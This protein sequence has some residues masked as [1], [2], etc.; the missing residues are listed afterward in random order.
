MAGD[1]AIEVKGLTKRFGARVALRDVSFRIEPGEVVAFLGPN[2]AGKSTTIHVLT[3]Q[4]E[5]DG[6]EVKVLGV[7]PRSDAAAIRRQLAFLPE[8]APLYEVLTPR[9]QLEFVAGVRGLDERTAAARANALIE[10]IGI[11]ELADLPLAHCSR[12]NRQRA[13]LACA[14]VEPPRLVVLDEPLFGLDAATVLLVKEILRKLAAS[15]VAVFYSSHLLDVAEN[16]ATRVLM[17]RE[18]EIVADGSPAKLLSGRAGTS[19]EGLFRE[20]TQESGIDERAERFLT[21]TRLAP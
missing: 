16:L 8:R 3:G 1:A 6:G 5:R 19:L 18:G 2:G 4:L 17:L 11:A 21:A 15:G 14:F 10:A 12:G 7:D 13:A 20:L 9:E